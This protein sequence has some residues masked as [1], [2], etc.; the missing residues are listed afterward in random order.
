MCLR[1]SSRSFPG[2][3]AISPQR[4]RHRV[5]PGILDARDHTQ[6][7]FTPVWRMRGAVC[8]A[9]VCLE[10]M[11]AFV[12]FA[13]ALHSA[14]ATCS[15][16]RPGTETESANSQHFLCALNTFAAHVSFKQPQAKL[17]PAMLLSEPRRK[18]PVPRVGRSG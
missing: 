10:A 16:R 11:E 1:L 4:K 7:P 6:T 18:F 17:E 13:F 5:L 2:K 9:V 8:F 15:R 14:H 3:S 12:P